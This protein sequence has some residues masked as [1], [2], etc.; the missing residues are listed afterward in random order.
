MLAYFAVLTIVNTT[1]DGVDEL[2]GKYFN[3]ALWKLVVMGVKVAPLI[4]GPEKLYQT[5]IRPFFQEIEEPVDSVLI[6]ASAKKAELQPQVEKLVH[7]R[8]DQIMHAI[9]KGKDAVAQAV[10][11]IKSKLGMESED[12]SKQESSH[13]DDDKLVQESD[14]YTPADQIHQRRLAQQGRTETDL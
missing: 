4:C 2:F 6:A 1:K 3:P 14:E 10:S 11:P 13:A 9:D 7:E 12:S 8:T 5:L